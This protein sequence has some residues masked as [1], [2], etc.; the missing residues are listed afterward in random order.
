MM[1]GS[2]A[3]F[4]PSLPVMLTVFNCMFKTWKLSNACNSFC[5]I[6]QEL[7]KL[8]VMY[9]T[10]NKGNAMKRWVHH[11]V[12]LSECFFWFACK[13][14]RSWKLS[15]TGQWNGNTVIYASNQFILCQGTGS[16]PLAQNLLQLTSKKMEQNLPAWATGHYFCI[17]LHPNYTPA[18]PPPLQKRRFHLYSQAQ[19]SIFF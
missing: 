15:V 11:S 6:Q 12:F 8:I 3:V 5:I 9:K 7:Q 13:T 18:P 1:M 2:L 19:C 17:L 14:F 16:K 4:F 10:C